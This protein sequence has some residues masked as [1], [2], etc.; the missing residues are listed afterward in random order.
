MAALRHLALFQ[1]EVSAHVYY[2]V[3]V[4]DR[5]GTF[6]LAGATSDAVPDGLLTDDVAYDRERCAVAI[7]A[8]GQHRPDIQE[9]VP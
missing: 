7:A 1:N 9:V 4:L 6:L 8:F 5:Y 3:D 2:A